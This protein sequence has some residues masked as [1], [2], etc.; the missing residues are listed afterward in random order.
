MW[1]FLRI[2]LQTITFF[3][4]FFCAFFSA[5]ICWF[6]NGLE[7]SKFENS[8]LQFK[9]LRETNIYGR[10]LGIFSGSTTT[11][12]KELSGTLNRRQFWHKEK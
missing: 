11:D 7:W 6:A 1:V 10:L 3:M 5:I 8:T 9:K 12:E 2:F 4:N